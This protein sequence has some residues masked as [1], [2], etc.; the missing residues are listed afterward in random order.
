MNASL[1]L[2]PIFCASLG[3]ASDVEPVGRHEG[4]RLVTPVNQIVT[5]AGKQVEL[6]GMRA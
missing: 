4:G 6:P 3:A 1:Y 2:I 5:S